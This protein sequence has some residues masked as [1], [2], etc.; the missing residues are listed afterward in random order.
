MLGL[1]PSVRLSHECCFKQL[2][3]IVS[4]FKQLYGKK[5]KINLDL[6]CL[7]WENFVDCKGI[8]YTWIPRQPLT[9]TL[10]KTY[11][12]SLEWVYLQ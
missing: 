3:V 8:G 10:G 6:D 12:V 5:H 7:K 2:F 11:L 9:R 1:F 4:N